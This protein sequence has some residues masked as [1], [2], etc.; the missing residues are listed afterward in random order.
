MPRGTPYAPK[1]G[2]LGTPPACGAGALDQGEISVGAQV[3]V[4][5][6][7]ETIAELFTDVVEGLIEDQD[8]GM[9]AVGSGREALAATNGDRE[10]FDVIVLDIG[11][12]DMNGFDLWEQLKVYCPEAETIVITDGGSVDSVVRA[13]KMGAFDFLEKPFGVLEASQTIRNAVEK[14][15][16]R[17][18]T[19]ELSSSKQ[20]LEAELNTAA[21]QIEQ[22]RDMINFTRIINKHLELDAILDVV[23]EQLPKM[24]NADS[25]SLFLYESARKEFQLIITNRTT[26]DP[27]D[28][29][30]VPMAES[31]TMRTTI[32]SREAVFVED[33][34]TIG[35][36]PADY[37]HD[38]A[39]KKHHSVCIPLNVSNRPIGV[40][41]L[42]DF[43]SDDTIDDNMN[44]AAV[45]I[46]HLAP[47]ISNAILYGQ[48]QEAANRDG[49][50]GLYNRAFYEVQMSENFRRSQRYGRPLSLLV[51]DI[52]HFKLFNDE[53]G[54]QVG[55]AVLKHVANLLREQMRVGLDIV[56]RY[57][58]EEMVMIA[59]ETPAEGMKIVAERVRESIEQSPYDY[60]TG[61][62]VNPLSV[63][64][65]IGTS[66]F[67]PDESEHPNERAL[68]R[69][70]DEA[71]YEAKK[72]GRNRTVHA[73]YRPDT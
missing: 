28:P 47:A 32:E 71:M 72:Q 50:T 3:L 31:T 57:G 4:I 16:F 8:V 70:A 61:T 44:T 24:L 63:T 34:R 66:T 19:A 1:R 30:V 10:P 68:F 6:D 33:V 59:P 26:L 29:L 60:N 17:Q 39:Y 65:S 41:N 43:H 42:N 9:V 56:A 35:I 67:T 2:R 11:L 27:R 58:G 40:I 12:P 14:K 46:E 64:V 23:H 73:N 53:H 36:E 7:E 51:L 38:R 5:D 48:I 49:L 55:D 25:F 13:M 52:D 69:T 20:S 22:V 62:E 21:V 37:D 45:V 54:H 15:R 18:I